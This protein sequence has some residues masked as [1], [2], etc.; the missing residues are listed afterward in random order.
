LALKNVALVLEVLTAID[1]LKP[2]MGEKEGAPIQELLKKL[3]KAGPA[4]LPLA[5]LLRAQVLLRTGQW[6]GGLA[7]LKELLNNVDTPQDVAQLAK[8]YLDAATVVRSTPVDATA[9]DG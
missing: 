7:L 3:D 8:A 1:A 6:V 5:T 2:G 4:W 9:I